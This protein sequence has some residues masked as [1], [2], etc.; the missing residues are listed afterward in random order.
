ML[1]CQIV[2]TPMVAV[3]MLVMAGS[4]AQA[5]TAEATGGLEGGSGGVNWNM[6]RFR[7]IAGALHIMCRLVLVS[8][9]YL[10][11]FRLLSTSANSLVHVMVLCSPSS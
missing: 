1:P 5:S 8:C 9:C 2:G 7:F 4:L 6:R 10:R 11:C 3:S